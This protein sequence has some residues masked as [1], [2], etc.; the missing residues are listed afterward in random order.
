M[1]FCTF[2][3]TWRNGNLLL[4]HTFL[5]DFALLGIRLGDQ[6]VDP[7]FQSHEL[8]LFER[9]SFSVGGWNP[10]TEIWTH[11]PQFRFLSLL[12]LSPPYSQTVL[13]VDVVVVLSGDVPELLLL[14]VRLSPGMPV[15]RPQEVPVA[16]G[17]VI[18]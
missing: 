8:C 1:R 16:A 14:G 17:S 6:T 18:P 3:K 7:S 10:E 11:S 9:L 12:I 13:F 5:W 2:Y 15:D 4:H